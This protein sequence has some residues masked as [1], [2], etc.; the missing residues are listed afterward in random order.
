MSQESPQPTPGA[1]AE[2]EDALESVGAV[3][4]TSD[5]APSSTDA[6]EAPAQ[7]EP[8]QDEVEQDEVA[9]QTGYS[10]RT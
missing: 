7:D 5:V 6:D 1:E 9:A 10:R 2:L 4:G 8:V 3:E